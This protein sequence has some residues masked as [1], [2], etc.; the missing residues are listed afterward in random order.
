MAVYTVAQVKINDG[1]RY[2]KYRERFGAVLQQY[3]GRLVA[4]DDNPVVQE[5]QWSYEKIVILEF[6]DLDAFNAFA[7]SESYREIAAHRHAG[8]DSL[9]LVA[10][11][12]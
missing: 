8:A 1:E 12:R 9:I 4:A 3:D 5:G 11:G 10:K 6:A 7:D 2:E